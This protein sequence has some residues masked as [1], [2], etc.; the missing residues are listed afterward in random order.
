MT[1]R[2][3]EKSREPHIAGHSVLPTVILAEFE[4]PQCPDDI[5]FNGRAIAFDG[6]NLWADFA[7]IFSPSPVP[8][9]H[10]TTGGI[11]GP[12]GCL[13]I[14][15]LGIPAFAEL[16]ALSNPD[17]FGNFYGGDYTFDGI[18]NVYLIGGLLSGVPNAF[19]IFNTNTIFPSEGSRSNCGGQIPGLLDGV[20]YD[21]GTNT[22]WISDDVGLTVY[23]VSLGPVPPIGTV[24]SSFTMPGIG[25][26]S[27]I[28]VAG[29]TLWLVDIDIDLL[30]SQLIQTDFLGN[31]LTTISLDDYLAEDIAFDPLTFAPKCAIWTN[32]AAVGA[33]LIR[34][35]EVPCPQVDLA[36]DIKPQSCPNPLNVKS[37][38][39]LPVA[40]LGSATFDVNTIDLASI[41]LEG[42]PPLRHNFEDVAT[43]FVGEECECT[44]EGPDNIMDLT[45]KFDKQAIIGAL[46][47]VDDRNEIVLTFT[48]DL[49]DGTS[50]E[51]KDCVIILKKGRIPRAIN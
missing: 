12:F 30:V 13:V 51:G 50:L 9:E 19:P 42:V 28:T 2:K 24:I 27:G 4:L 37:R 3:T 7:P 41:R 22:L 14:P 34:A 31:P 10:L 33:P 43:P 47:D 15:N 26:N 1:I 32:E 49:M 6:T 23:N 36:I 20:E 40:I 21:P 35:Y 17:A 29:N 16:G 45:L 48:A 39:V 46:G 25:C 5:R 8:I 18:G 38:G 11:F 44:D